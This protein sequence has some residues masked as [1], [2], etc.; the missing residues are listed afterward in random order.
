MKP[1]NNQPIGRTQAKNEFKPLAVNK[2]ITITLQEK[3][4]LLIL[5][6]HAKNQLSHCNAPLDREILDLPRRNP[7]R[8]IRDC[9]N[10]CKKTI[11]SH[12]NHATLNKATIKQELNLQL[13]N[14]YKN[15]EQQEPADF[16]KLINEFVDSAVTLAIH[17][18]NYIGKEKTKS[19][20]FGVNSTTHID[21]LGN[22]KK[23]LKNPDAAKKINDPLEIEKIR[24][25]IKDL[26]EAPKAEPGLFKKSDQELKLEQQNQT[27]Q[28]KTVDLEK[29]LNETEK[30]LKTTEVKLTQLQ[31][32]QNQPQ[33]KLKQPPH[34]NPIENG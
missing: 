29:K 14:L 22:Y 33:G 2:E 31:E 15:L 6:H 17:E 26:Q 4:D 34:L 28:K 10:A 30:Q 8:L 9:L 32:K 18:S 3:D 24:K 12:L 19:E 20:F 25:Y 23:F 27:L 16:D 11:Q 1:I 5:A 13:T 21:K 7:K